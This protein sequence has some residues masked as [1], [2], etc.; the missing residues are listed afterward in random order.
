MARGIFRRWA[1]P[2]SFAAAGIGTAAVVLLRG[3]WHR[4]MSWPTR[5]DDRYSYRVCTEFGIKRL[6]DPESFRGYGPYSYDLKDLIARDR[7]RRMKRQHAVVDAS[8][9]DRWITESAAFG[10]NSVIEQMRI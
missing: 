2:L 7:A 3:C 1:W 8:V 6:F 4:H 5:Y 9:L 10:F